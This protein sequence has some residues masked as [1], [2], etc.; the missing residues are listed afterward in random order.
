L[1]VASVATL[2]YAGAKSSPSASPKGYWRHRRDARQ[3]WILSSITSVWRLA[4]D[5]QQASQSG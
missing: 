5:R 4:V 3:G 2:S 1:L